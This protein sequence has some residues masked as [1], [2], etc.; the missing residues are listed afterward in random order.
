MG[1]RSRI[2]I[3]NSDDS[4]DS[5]YCHWDGYP[6][7]NG[8]LLITH[9]TD[10]AKVRELIALGDLSSL[11]PEIGEQHPFDT[12]DFPGGYEAH[13]KLYGH[14]C[15]AYG[16]DRG[17]KDCESQH[18]GTVQEYLSIDCGAEYYY[19]F[20]YGRWMV[21]STEQNKWVLAED[22]LKEAA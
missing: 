11:A 6:K 8:R 10:E 15:M 9:Y 5:I 21:F 18:S 16:R 22:V 20:H 7:H 12:H 19:I 14:M 4:V 1:T 3:R 17:E 2:A 13:N